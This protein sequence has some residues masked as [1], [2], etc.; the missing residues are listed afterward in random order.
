LSRAS[1]S[2]ATS[3]RTAITS[4][5]PRTRSASPR[6]V[7]APITALIA[8]GAPGSPTSHGAAVAHGCRNSAVA[9][10]RARVISVAAVALRWPSSARS[11][12]RRRGV[13]SS[14]ASITVSGDMTSSTAGTGGPSS[15]R[16]DTSSAPPTRSTWM[17]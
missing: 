5:A 6:S 16:T 7:S 1:P 14:A 11:T 4:S 2:P 13:A 12:P 10:N 17:G 3:G 9:E 15:T 8:V